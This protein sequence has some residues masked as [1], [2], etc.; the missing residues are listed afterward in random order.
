M[1]FAEAKDVPRKRPGQLKT[2]GTQLFRRYI[3]Y[4]LSVRTKRREV[5]PRLL[6]YCYSFQFRFN[7]QKRLWQKLSG[8]GTGSEQELKDGTIA[9]SDLWV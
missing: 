9:C 3:P 5:N 7:A 2:A 6:Q 4:N 8:F 1:V